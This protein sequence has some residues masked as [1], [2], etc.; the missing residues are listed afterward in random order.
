MRGLKE[1]LPFE[2]TAEKILQTQTRTSFL[3]M[4]NEAGCVG[5]KEEA[6]NTEKREKAKGRIFLTGNTEL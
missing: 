6:E 1:F 4:L 2:T 5:K 3:T